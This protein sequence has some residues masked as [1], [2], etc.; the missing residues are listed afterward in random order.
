MKQI[1]L[2]MLILSAFGISAQDL[3]IRNINVI[4][5]NTGKTLSNYAV[6]ITNGKIS[7]V[8]EDRK[9]KVANNTSVIQGDGRYLM[10][11]LIDSHIH[12][13]QSGSLYTRPDG[14]DLTNKFPYEKEREQGLANSTDY[15]KRYLRLG[16]TTV[17]DAGGPFSN[18]SIRDSISK[19][20]ISPNIL[21]TGPLFSIIE[22]KAIEYNDPPIVKISSDKEADDLFNKM[23]PFKPDFIKIW[24][25]ADKEYPAEKSFPLVKHI[26]ELCALHKLQLAVHATE[27]NTARLAVKAGANILVHSIE[28][29]VIPDDFVKELKEKNVT[30]IPTL[31]VLDNYNNVFSGKL[32]HHRQD[33][34]WANAFAYGSLTDLE[35]MD[36]SALPGIIKWFRRSGIPPIY[37]RYDSNMRV[38]LKKV[39]RGGVNVASGTDAGNIGTQ[40]GSSYLQELEAMSSA[41]LTNAEIL[42]AST[43]NGAYGFGISHKVGSIEKGK[44]A[45]LIMLQGN[46]LTSINNINS[47]QFVMKDGKILSPDSIL[48]ESPEEIV[49]RQVN[50]YNARDIDAFV[51]TYSEDVQIYDEKGKLLITGHEQLRKEYANYF[52]TV[53]NLHCEIVNRIV[54]N[55]KVIDKEKI[56]A[57][58]DIFYGVALYEV[59]KGKIVKVSFI[60]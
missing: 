27:L 25:I 14:L 7:W 32:P 47:I 40:H 48:S 46:P 58:K 1:I 33:L 20:T 19:K 49:Q 34:A 59:T 51:S 24:Y 41:G 3:A 50:A 57:G 28:D 52:K 43:I 44:Y 15:L 23:L 29:E 37:A 39:V 6:Q 11:G 16:I 38:N 42:K 31:I 12:F 10:P 2:S 35:A 45:D 8:G 17:I 9:M 5:V 55:N 21:V 26:A 18:F 53:P 30:Y 36:T 4:D 56:R 13:F 54:Y 60:E 22:D